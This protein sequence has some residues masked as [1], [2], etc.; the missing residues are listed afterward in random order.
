MVVNLFTINLEV[1]LPVLHSWRS[2]ETIGRIKLKFRGRRVKPQTCEN[3]TTPDYTTLRNKSPCKSPHTY[4]KTNHHPRAKKLQDKTY[5]IN[6]IVTQEDRL[7]C[8]HIGCPK[9]HI[10][11]RPI[12]KLITG[13]SHCTPERRNPFPHSRTW[14]QASLIRKP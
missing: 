5:Y 2:L 6:S 12:A 14:T 8:Q 1:L 13:H 3:H 11:H 9:S 7:K 4:T 10:T